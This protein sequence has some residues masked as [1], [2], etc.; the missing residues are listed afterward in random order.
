[1]MGNLSS[2]LKNHAVT[3]FEV[4]KLSEESLE[5][6]LA[7]LG[8][9]SEADIEGDAQRY[10]EHAI[11]LRTTLNFLRHNAAFC[12]QNNSADAPK[13]LGL[14]LLRC[15]SLQNLD[16]GTYC[17]LLNR[18]YELV[19]SMA[20]LC[21]EV[22]LLESC[23]PAH[24]GPVIPEINS[25][26]FKL[27]LYYYT[28][29]GPTSLFLTQGSK[30]RRTPKC[31]LQSNLLRCKSKDRRQILVTSWSGSNASEMCLS[32]SLV[33]LNEILKDTSLL[34]QFPGAA[35]VGNRVK[36]IPFPLSLDNPKHEPGM[37]DFTPF[38]H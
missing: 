26:W 31:F 20:P 19:V 28:G 5:S 4:G 23:Q 17:R 32:N 14:D 37:Y 24:L 1:M 10:L 16:P 13:G 2:G 11:N 3:M 25:V 33:L 27:F 21:N 38:A 35:G 30:L 15:E 6:L 7:E 22:R 8:K 18:N 12:G 36:M 34:L 29:H 9:I